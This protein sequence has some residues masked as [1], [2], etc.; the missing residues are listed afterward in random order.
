[1]SSQDDIVTSEF[2]TLDARFSNHPLVTSPPRSRLQASVRLLLNGHTV[3]TS[4]CYRIAPNK[5]AAEPMDLLR[6]LAQAVM[7]VL[8]KRILDLTG[9]SSAAWAHSAA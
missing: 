4:C 9:R 7:K 1:M 2:T 5:H 3:G 8:S 6:V